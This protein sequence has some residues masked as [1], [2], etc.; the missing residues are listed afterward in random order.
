MSPQERRVPIPDKQR[1]DTTAT[2]RIS[3]ERPPAEDGDGNAMSQQEAFERILAALHEA[4]LDD[5]RWDTASKLIDEACGI[6]GNCVVVGDEL[7]DLG[8]GIFFSWL[9]YRGERNTELAREYFSTYHHLD[10]RFPRLRR[11]PDS[12]LVRVADLYSEPER[13]TSPVYNDVLVRSESRNGL[14]V[15]LDG[16]EGSCIVWF[17]ADPVDGRWSSAQVEL[18]ERLLPHLRQFVVVRH[19]LAEAGAL[20]ASLARLLDN[21]R[22]GVI[23]LDRRGRIVAANDAARD[24]LRQGDGLSDQDGFLRARVPAEHTALQR[25]LARALPRFGEPSES[26]SITV[27]RSP[28]APHLVLHVSPVEDREVDYRAQRP[29]ALVL[30]VDPDDD[31]PGRVEPD[32]D[33]GDTARS[34]GTND[35]DSA[36]PAWIFNVRGVGYRMA[37][38]RQE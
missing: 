8:V 4:A 29:A 25:L 33:D 5:A 12:Q 24:V 38:P 34:N 35:A 37:R 11:L 32:A 1:G 10:E 3:V 14:S 13:K 23:H 36:N 15:R 27:S 21:P 31:A 7:P 18:L 2:L 28:E 26:G 16:P 17:T 20:G 22:A 9:C 30:V 6:K 19:A